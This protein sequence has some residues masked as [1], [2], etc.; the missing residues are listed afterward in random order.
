M[1]KQVNIL[2]LSDLHFDMESS[3]KIPS[4][5][6]DRR[7]LTLDGLIK[8]LKTLDPAWRPH[9]VAISGDIAWKAKPEDYEKAEEWLTTKLLPALKLEHIEIFSRPF[10]AF[11]GFC[12]NIV[13]SP[14]SIGDQFSFLTGMVYIEGLRL[15]S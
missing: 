7:N 8:T 10:D 4:T 5:A 15:Q 3:E 13:L 2:H 1:A 11:T 12:E 9:V 6:V 14:P